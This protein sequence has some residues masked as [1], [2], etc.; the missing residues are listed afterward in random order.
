MNCVYVGK[1]L[2]IRMVD[3]INVFKVIVK[4]LWIRKKVMGDVIKNF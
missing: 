4:V 1:K 3:V 2:V